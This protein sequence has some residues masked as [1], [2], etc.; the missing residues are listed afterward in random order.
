M[1]LEIR[2]IGSIV[3][4][5]IL[6]AQNERLHDLH[7]LDFHYIFAET[8]NTQPEHVLGL[9]RKDQPPDATG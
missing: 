2:R 5:Q 7:V 1:P 6:V 8:P 3:Q 9:S 4:L